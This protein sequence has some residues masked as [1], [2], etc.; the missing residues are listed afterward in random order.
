MS[1]SSK[2]IYIYTYTYI[3]GSFN[4]YVKHYET[5]NDQCPTSWMFGHLRSVG[6]RPGEWVVKRRKRHGGT[7]TIDG[8]FVFKSMHQNGWLVVYLPL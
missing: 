3:Y 6:G 5:T 2:Y 8:D 1:V 7:Q 4:K